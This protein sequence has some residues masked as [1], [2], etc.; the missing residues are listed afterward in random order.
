MF[1]SNLN[2]NIEKTK[3]YNNKFLVGNTDMKISSNRDMNKDHK[4]LPVTPLDVS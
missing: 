2:L 3:G 1:P 4:K